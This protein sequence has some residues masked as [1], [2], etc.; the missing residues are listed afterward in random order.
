MPWQG[1]LINSV[2]AVVGL[3]WL[4]QMNLTVM[5]TSGNFAK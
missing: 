2:L 3:V 4:S 1:D 5:V